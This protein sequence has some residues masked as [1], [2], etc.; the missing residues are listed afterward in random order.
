MKKR[1]SIKTSRKQRHGTHSVS[2]NVAG[3]DRA[4]NK[5]KGTTG[6]PIEISNKPMPQK[7]SIRGM[8][9][10]LVGTHST[11][12]AMRLR[13]G[14]L[15][16]NLRLSLKYVQFAASYVDGKPV[17]THRMVGLSEGPTGTYDLT[18]LSPKDRAAL[19]TLLRS[20]KDTTEPKGELK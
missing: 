7:R 13:E 3:D 20:A 16:P 5:Q 14:M 6:A 8:L 18:K 4:S 11:E 15:S 19:L 9:R 1:R 10:E 2:S 17:E 12:I